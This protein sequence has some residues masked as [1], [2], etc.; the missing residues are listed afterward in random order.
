MLETLRA[1]GYPYLHCGRDLATAQAALTELVRRTRQPFGLAVTG[2]PA[3]LVIPDQVTRV[4]LPWGTDDS[5]VPP[6]AERVWQVTNLP[7]A[8]AALGAGAA[9]A[10]KGNDAA[11]RVGDEST[12]VLFQRVL[13][14]AGERPVRVFVHG[15]VGVHTAAAY[16]ALGAAGVHFDSQIALLPECDAP[17]EFKAQLGRLSGGE[18][19]LIRGRRVLRWPTMPKPAADAPLEPFFGG[20]DPERHLIPLGQDIA[21]ASEFLGR[22]GR[23]DVV[24]AAIREAAY[25]HLRQA[26]H[27]PALRAHSPLARELGVT[28]PLVQGPMARVSDTPAF[29]AAVAAAGALPML[30]IG[31]STPE[32]TARLLADTHETMGDAPWGAGLL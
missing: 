7:D 12:F 27:T 21:L 17:A 31:M 11:G 15:G 19:T 29:L 23:L 4:L 16:L 1:G 22:Y 30:T 2:N 14:L 8:E 20:L 26:K 28:Y 32:T 18:T 10:V 24:L 25:G 3:G 13:G 9:I 6:G 5:A